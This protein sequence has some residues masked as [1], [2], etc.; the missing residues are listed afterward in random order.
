MAS[1]RRLLV[2]AAAALLVACAAPK[3]TGPLLVHPVPPPAG[4]P[5]ALAQGALVYAGPGFTVSARPWDW[6]LVEEELRAAGGK[7]PFGDKPGETGRFLFF[8]VR[9]ENRSAKN[10]VFNPM[11][12]A[13]LREGEAPVPPLETSDLHAFAGEEGEADARSRTF[14]RVGFDAAVTLR[15]GESLERYLVFRSPAEAKL[16][17]LALD[18]LWLG[19]QDHDLKFGFEAFPGK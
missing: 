5:Y 15:P 10:L 3:V 1:S 6:R 18:D 17:T 13:V 2:A 19:A 14:R 4:E 8:R 9:L 16:L 11:R 7:S 12:A